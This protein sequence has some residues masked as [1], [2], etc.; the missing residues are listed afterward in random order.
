MKKII[1]AASISMALTLCA[2]TAYLTAGTSEVPTAEA[3]FRPIG[4]LAADTEWQLLTRSDC[5]TCDF[6]GCNC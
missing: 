5:V 3:G 2:G 6:D 1:K 4:D